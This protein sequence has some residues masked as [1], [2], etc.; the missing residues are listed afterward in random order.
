[1]NVR[2][3]ATAAAA[4]AVL[5][6]CTT[7]AG[8]EATTPLS[9][10]AT[11]TYSQWVG[12]ND[13]QWRTDLPVIPDPAQG[14]ADRDSGPLRLGSPILQPVSATDAELCSAGAWFTDSQGGNV[15]LTAAHCDKNPG[16]AV[17]VAPRD[18]ASREELIPIGR[19]TDHNFDDTAVLR[20]NPGV[21]PAPDS[22]MVAGR[23]P[24]SGVLQ[25]TEE[26][27]PPRGASVCV[28]A[29]KVGV[30]CGELTVSTAATVLVDIPLRSGPVKGNSGGSAWLID[31]N[32][33]AVLLGVVVQAAT[34]PETTTFKV[35]TAA[36]LVSTLDLKLVE[37][38]DH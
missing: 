9:L 27:V 20:L 29:S 8:M 15:L 31:T 11:E 26:A 4:A 30:Q 36:S 18:L 17:A 23:W 38:S 32:N 37:G 22:T 21:T 10:T 33:R 6:G 3:V 7:D 5:S 34:T 25:P 28:V 19:Y 16:E 24:A 12:A 2:M 35:R 1:M 14:P 13:R